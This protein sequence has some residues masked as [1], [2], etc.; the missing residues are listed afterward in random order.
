MALIPAPISAF[1]DATNAGDSDAFVA[2]FAEDGSL[3]DWGRVAHGHAG[4]REWDRTDN[5][6]K[7]SHFELVDIAAE[8]PPETYLV[9]LAVTGNGFNGTSPFRFTLRD[10]LIRS[11]VIVPD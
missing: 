11:V 9:H 1:I 7:Q 6:G 8:A 4:I 2:A 5:I 10:G 3:D